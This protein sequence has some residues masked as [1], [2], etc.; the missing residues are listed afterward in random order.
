MEAVSFA[1]FSVL[2]QLAGFVDASLSK[3]L[4]FLV[5]ESYPQGELNQDASK[6]PDVDRSANTV[7]DII[8]QLKFWRT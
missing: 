1:E 8:V 6:R 2:W 4:P 7:V 3:L 5:S